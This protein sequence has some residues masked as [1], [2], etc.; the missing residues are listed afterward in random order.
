MTSKH[1][2]WQTRWQIDASAREARHECGL[3]IAFNCAPGDQV[4]PAGT[5][6]NADAI[7]AA[8]A[9]SKGAHNV[10]PML[11]RLMREA[12]TLYGSYPHDSRH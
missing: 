4:R 8:L 12:S 2:R 11:A 6:R 5:A 9:P 1:Y 10:P 3:V 7:A